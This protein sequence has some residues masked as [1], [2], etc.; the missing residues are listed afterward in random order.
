MKATF[1]ATALTAAVLSMA[2][3]GNANA[4]D[5]KMYAGSGC[6]VF[7]STSWTDLHFGA[8]GITNVSGSPKTV[9]CPLI[10]DSE[11]GWD[12][13]ATNDAFV[14]YHLRSGPNTQLSTCNVYVT[15]SDGSIGQTLTTQ[16]GGAAN[17]EYNRDIFY[18]NDTGGFSSNHEHATMLCILAPGARLNYYYLYEQLASD[19]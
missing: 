10:K 8:A 19:V 18:F 7:G 4:A 1:I 16:A 15:G 14:H 9:I 6:K 2:P 11:S 13:G 12:D 17:T 3:T 5:S